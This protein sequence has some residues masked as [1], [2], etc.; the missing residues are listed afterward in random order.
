MP[1]RLPLRTRIA[2]I[3]LTTTALAIA[4][5]AWLTIRYFEAKLTE[6][7]VQTIREDVDELR[8]VLEEDML[9]SHTGSL[10]ALVSTMAREHVVAWVGIT[11]EN[12][13]VRVSSD[14]GRTNAVFP[15]GSPE[16][17]TFDRW[18]RSRDARSLAYVSGGCNVLRVIAP[19]ENR[20]SCWGCH[21]KQRSLT[22]MLIIDHP[23]KPLRQT[24]AVGTRWLALGGVGALVVILGCVGFVV[25]RAIL[26]R[27][28]R[29]RQAAKALGGGDLSARALDG[30]DDELSDVARE[31]DGMASRLEASMVSLAAQRHQLDQLVNGIADGVLLLDLEARLVAMNR[32]F[33]SRISGE[34]PLRGASYRELLLAVGVAAEPGDLPAV[35]ALASGKL[36]KAVLPARGGD[37][38]EELYA[39]P[40]L[41]ANGHPTAVIEVWRDITDRKVL[42]ASVEQSE[43]LASLGVLA[44]SVAHEVGNP[45]ASIVTAVD[46]LLARLPGRSG[47]DA[48]DEIREYLEIVRKQVFRCH[49]ATER[50]LGF[51]RVPSA[52]DESIVD[53]ASAAREVTTLIAPQASTQGVTVEVRAAGPALALAPHGMI[54]QVFLNLT[55]NALKT[56]PSGGTLRVDVQSDELTVNVLVADTGPGIPEDVAR[57]LFQ[58]FRTSRRDGRGTGLGL[59]ISQTLVQR[60]GGSIAAESGPGRGATFKVRLRR[61]DVVPPAEPTARTET[62]P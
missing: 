16:W 44:S 54:E 61:A 49:G 55:L 9:A 19:I 4:G 23:L 58:A 45:L 12:A 8:V 40:L 15:R 36:E 32:A 2:L 13:A 33:A 25:E 17:E 26:R 34:P 62:T 1:R 50:L 14:A 53:V 57:H 59:F 21:D 6:S 43:R 30:G 35:R 56:M 52:G 38:F 11:D 20:P 10:A 31:F 3:V 24:V 46:G 60:A 37:R 47:G 48:Q 5:V 27:L 41:D 51:A 42:E 29:L 39:Q 28:D 18:E 7:A 22:G